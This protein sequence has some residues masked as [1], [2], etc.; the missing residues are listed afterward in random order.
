MWYGVISKWTDVRLEIDFS[1]PLAPL[2]TFNANMVKWNG[3][4]VSQWFLKELF[5]T[6]GNERKTGQFKLNL[7]FA[8]PRN[9]EIEGK[10]YSV[11]GISCHA[12]R[13]YKKKKKWVS[14]SG[15]AFYDWHAGQ[16]KIPANGTVVGS[17]IESDLTTWPDYEGDIPQAAQYKG[18]V[19]A[20]LY[21]SQK[22]NPAEDSEVPDLKSL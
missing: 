11:A 13:I 7:T 6:Y 4:H 14:W 8:E 16:L 19:R 21:D 12:F 5:T 15:D 2:P 18:F 17:W 10:E 9:M 3:K 20:I 22:W 1:M